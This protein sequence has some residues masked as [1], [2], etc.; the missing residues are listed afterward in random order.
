[1][2]IRK[3]GDTKNKNIES[4]SNDSIFYGDFKGFNTNS[5]NQTNNTAIDQELFD[6][7]NQKNSKKSARKA[8]ILEKLDMYDM[9]IANLL[10][11]K[12]IIE[13]TEHLDSSEI[14]IGFSNIASENQISKYFVVR[15]FPDF[16]Q[17]RFIDMVRAR[18][19]KPGVKINF[20]I[21]G[22][23]YKVEWDSAEMRN[24]MMVW[25]NYADENSGP[26][27]VFDYRN[28]RNTDL[29]R[30][31]IILTTKYLNDAE[32]NQKRSFMRTLFMIEISA[33]RDEDSIINMGETIKSL[34]EL[35]TLYDI[36][37]NELRI[38]LIDWLKTF[39]IFSLMDD[40]KLL[41]TVPYKIM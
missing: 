7:V 13:P 26:V 38:N 3:K 21:H 12:A 33:S 36:K 35:C 14:K 18:C 41:S 32:L 15:K 39:G 31:R 30:K 24:K 27:N 17:T 10:A 25:K 1:M 4:H 23:P 8:K 2:G 11:G 9:I 6:R 19:I 5:N 16:M 37:L 20:Y 34:N 40:G 28:Q 22:S 29:A